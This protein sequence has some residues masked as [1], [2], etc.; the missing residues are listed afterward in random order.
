MTAWQTLQTNFNMYISDFLCKI[1]SALLTPT[2]TSTLRQFIRK[3][4]YLYPPEYIKAHIHADYIQLSHIK[5][6]HIIAYI[7]LQLNEYQ[8]S[9]NRTGSTFLSDRVNLPLHILIDSENIDY[10]IFSLRHANWWDRY[11]LFNQIKKTEFGETDWLYTA[12][13]PIK[14]DEQR[15]IF[16]HLQPCSRLQKNLAFIQSHLNSIIK[17][18][19]TSVQQTNTA[20][21]RIYITEPNHT[22]CPWIIFIQKI[23]AT[24]WLL[25]AQ[26]HGAIILSRRGIFPSATSTD[27]SNETTIFK[28]IVTTLR[29]LQRH[30][31]KENEAFTLITAG[32]SG[33]FSPSHT[34]DDIQQRLPI[35]DTHAI[36]AR[37]I[38]KR[39]LLLEE[40]IITWCINVIKT[41]FRVGVPHYYR[42]SLKPRI[43]APHR[44]AYWLP[45]IS[46]RILY[47]TTFACSLVTFWWMFQAICINHDII[48]IEQTKSILSHTTNDPIHMHKATFFQHYKNLRGLNPL[49][50]IKKL[51]AILGK[52]TQITQ[53]SWSSYYKDNQWHPKFQATLLL[54]SRLFNEKRKNIS[55]KS[56]QKYKQRISANLAHTINASI[57]W[58][59][60]AHKNIYTIGVSWK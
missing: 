17:I 4:G 10:R 46:L 18:Q 29:Y 43:F 12:H 1:R 26:H 30:K 40:S 27:E 21:N 47:T 8:R 14:E 20:I 39:M 45:F 56:Y 33:Q 60:T 13:V 24:E 35:A 49:D 52:D 28:E 3:I 57:T 48:K 15:Y 59:P 53:F 54:P 41:F 16:A 51:P 38:D 32:F 23:A 5:N 36:P 9:S 31:Y 42:R 50:F 37:D 58:T 25:T 6:K 19:I 34:T 11:G 22:F 2:D 7:T 44:S 55:H